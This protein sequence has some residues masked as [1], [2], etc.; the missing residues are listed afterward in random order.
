TDLCKRPHDDH[1]DDHLEGENAKKKKKTEE[2][3][4]S[5]YDLEEGLT[6]DNIKWVDLGDDSEKEIQMDVEMDYDDVY[7]LEEGEIPLE[8]VS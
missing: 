2:K 6:D 4:S 3:H 1:L 8:K 7:E 5:S